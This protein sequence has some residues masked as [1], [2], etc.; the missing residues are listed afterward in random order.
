MIS[1]DH[2][3]KIYYKDV[4]QMGIVYYSRYFEYF[5]ESRTELL[6]SIGLGVTGIEEKGIMLPVISSHC[7]YSKGAMFE[8]EITIRASIASIPRSKLHIDY[9]V[10]LDDY[11]E[12]LVNGYTEHAF[13]NDKGVA[14]RAPRSILD[15]L[16]KKGLK[17]V[18]K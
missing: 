18:G 3:I 2:C 17:P 13:V 11:T 4:D 1:Y 10:F 15:C 9:R 8:Q 7:D 16:Y 5:E 12:T 6:A 14:V